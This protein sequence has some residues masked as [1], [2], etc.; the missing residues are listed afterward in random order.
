MLGMLPFA[1]FPRDSF[2]FWMWE[3]IIMDSPLSLPI[4]L[5]VLCSFALH[6][7]LVTH[8]TQRE[9]KVPGG[10]CV[11]QTS[12][13]AD[14]IHHTCFSVSFRPKGRNSYGDRRSGKRYL[15]TDNSDLTAR[16]LWGFGN[17][18]FV[19]MEESHCRWNSTCSFWMSPHDNSS[20][21]SVECVEVGWRGVRIS[22]WEQKLLI[23]C[24]WWFQSFPV[25]WEGWWN[26]LL[27][28]ISKNVY[29]GPDSLAQ[30]IG[31]LRI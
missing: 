5:F 3:L 13:S 27:V 24:L 2:W 29:S 31:H 16:A 6:I 8:G 20:L 1:F 26:R 7:H 17:E 30:P 21:P 25:K 11:F 15:P 28:A 14:F 22:A 9:E 19:S 10:R 23:P 18:V 4:Q 12:P